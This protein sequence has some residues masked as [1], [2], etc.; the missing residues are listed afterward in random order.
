MVDSH[1]QPL[2]SILYILCFQGKDTGSLSS[3]RL[4]LETHDHWGAYEGLSMLLEHLGLQASNIGHHGSFTS[5]WPHSCY[6]TGC[7]PTKEF[8]IFMNV[9][10]YTHHSCGPGAGF[11]HPGHGAPRLP[12]LNASRASPFILTIDSA[13]QMS[14]MTPRQTQGGTALA[15][16]PVPTPLLY[17]TR[18]E[19][20]VCVVFTRLY[21]A[22]S[23]YLPDIC[24]VNE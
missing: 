10:Q 21:T 16:S 11:P 12:P 22:L 3:L 24:G 5:R 13:S 20:S 23:T 4:P 19:G 1:N 14:E 8:F 6:A 9:Q 17:C 15:E 7:F 18:H 2:E